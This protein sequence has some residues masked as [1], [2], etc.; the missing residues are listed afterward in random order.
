M[1]P[2]R[3]EDIYDYKFPSDL[4]WAPEGE[5]AAFVVSSCDPEQNRYQKNIWILDEN[6][7]RRLTGMDEE[8]TY[9]WEDAYHLVFTA[10]RSA[11]DRQLAEQ[12]L[13][14]TSYYRIDVRGGEAVFAFRLPISSGVLY[15]LGNGKYA[16]VGM[17]RL[18]LPDLYLYNEADR[19]AILKSIWE[20]EDYEVLEKIPYWF[21]GEGHISNV[22]RAIYLWDSVGGQ[23]QRLTGEDLHVNEVVVEGGECFFSAY[24]F[25]ERMMDE[26]M[27]LYALDVNAE[28]GYSIRC[29]VEPK[30]YVFEG[31]CIDP[32]HVIIKGDEISQVTG[33]FL[34]ADRKTGKIRKMFP[35][36][37]CLT[38]TVGSD[39]RMGGGY[40]L[41]YHAGLLYYVC[42][43]GNSSMLYTMDAHGE[44]KIF[45]NL[46]GGAYTFDISEHGW[47]M[48]IGQYGMRLPEVYLLERGRARQITHINDQALE[49]KYV[50]VPEKTV[51]YSQGWELDG[52]ALKPIDYDPQNRYPA[53]LNIHGGP[54]TV[55]GE[56][57]HHEMQFWASCGYFVLFCNPLGSDGRGN[58][59]AFSLV[60]ENGEKAYYNLM[61]FVDTMLEK[62]PQIDPTRVAVTG[63]SFGGYMTN[64]IIGHTDRFACAATQRSI[65]NGLTMEAMSDWG[66]LKN[67]ATNKRNDDASLLRDMEKVWKRSPI[68]YAKNFKTPTL[69]IHSDH[70]F[71]CP[72]AEGYQMFYALKQM[73]I[74]SK[75]VVFKGEGH[76]LSRNGKPRHRVRRLQE[77]TRWIERYTK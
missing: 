19:A 15:A 64:W 40:A 46:E 3:I 2:I 63:G 9:Y 41:K 8:S 38:S 35:C 14:Y 73:G 21:D 47:I 17:M 54:K 28:G 48:L 34:F 51:F 5:R 11:K 37:R 29:L 66:W 18:D 10:I 30:K 25:D 12:G 36:S 22:R 43:N 7:E 4:K 49:G 77:I 45:A 65:A 13:G 72:I 20:E 6:G 42:T 56:I 74:P 58:E 53:I 32:E 62:Y 50:A 71:R 24:H 69:I 59:F 70:D 16:T 61:D 39:C 31:I 60:G 55:F 44:E 52:W 67:E 57:F 33:K 26:R 1:K 68:K 27:G 23:M 75:M 76:S